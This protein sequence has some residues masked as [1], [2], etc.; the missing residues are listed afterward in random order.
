MFPIL[1][2]CPSMQAKTQQVS[3][4]VSSNIKCFNMYNNI[5]YDVPQCNV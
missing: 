3:A 1:Q 2:A 4:L 5:S